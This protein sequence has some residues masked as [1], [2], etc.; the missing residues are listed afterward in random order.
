M[1]SDT[2]PSSEFTSQA[3]KPETKPYL[4][5]KPQNEPGFKLDDGKTLAYLCVSDFAKA[6]LAVANVATY[7]AKKYT[8][9]GWRTVPDGIERYSE[10]MMRHLLAHSAGEMMDPE[11]NHTHMAHVCW[12]ALAVLELMIAKE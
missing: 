6:I 5:C 2:D 4:I 9:R 3:V 11:S 10:A 12:N 8:K 1:G 7:G